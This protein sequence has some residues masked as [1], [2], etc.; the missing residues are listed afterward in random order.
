MSD[1][2][3]FSDADLKK[4]QQNVPQLNKEGRLNRWSCTGS[5]TTS[6]TSTTTN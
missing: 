4:L 2:A 1:W 3:G 6:T 5:G